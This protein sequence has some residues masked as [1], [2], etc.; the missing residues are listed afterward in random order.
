MAGSGAW[1]VAF[2]ISARAAGDRRE[3]E[4]QSWVPTRTGSLIRSTPK[5]C[6]T[7]SLIS[8]ARPIR[9]AVSAPPWLVSASVCLEEMRAGPV[10]GYPLPKPA[11]S[12]S[13]AADIFTCPSGAG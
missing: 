3:P 2:M 13:H 11:C 8:L 5:A 12:I 4:L 10:P 1:A 6:R 7:P 9:L